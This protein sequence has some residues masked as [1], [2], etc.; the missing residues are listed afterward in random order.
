[1]KKIAIVL[2][3]AFLSATT[4]SAVANNNE[5]IVIESMKCDGNK[6]KVEQA[7]LP[8]E[9]IQ[10]LEESEFQNWEIKEAY[11]VEDEM[12]NEVHYELHLASDMDVQN[13]KSV[14]ISED[15]EILSEED[16]N[17]GR[18]EDQEFEQYEQPQT[19]PGFE[20][21]EPGIEQDDEVEPGFEGEGTEPG[22]E[23]TEQQY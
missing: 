9:V 12:T 11:K 6:Q 4:L 23:G 18:T 13:I 2:A 17:L 21:T 20:G 22:F 1:M 10:S 7:E 5:N 19:E 15:G 8:Q 14:T 3:G 16:A